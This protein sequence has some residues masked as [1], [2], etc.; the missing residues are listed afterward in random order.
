M[1]PLHTIALALTTLLLT[2]QSSSSLRPDPPIACDA[3]DEW[4]APRTP[5]RIFGNT[6]FVGVGG[7]SAV[8]ITSPEGHVL[9]DGGLPQ[10]AAPIDANIRALGFRTEDVRLIFSSHAHY[11]HVGGIAALQRLSG[12]TVVSSAA[13]ARAL[14]A[15][16]PTPDDPQYALGRAANA[17]PR[18]SN[19]RAV[20]DGAVLRLGDIAVTV[21]HTPGHTPGGTTT[22]WKACEGD[23]CVDVVYADSLT[24]VSADGFRF[25]GDGSTPDRSAQFR[26]TIEKVAALP[27]DIVIAAHPGFTDI[28]GKLA[29]RAKG[30]R[31]DP[32]I[33]A[34]GCR[35]Y[36]AAARTRLEARLAEERRSR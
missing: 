13:G 36:A 21:H 1:T 28:D 19:V 25:L 17:F 3:C 15:G 30:E 14:E 9:V 12:A 22:T 29:R 27:C 7:L 2:G 5:F 20:E 16:E 8:L 33:E 35:A 26:A 11:D 23:R 24:A 4:N 34:G 6:W 31:P 32:F 10:S 18:V